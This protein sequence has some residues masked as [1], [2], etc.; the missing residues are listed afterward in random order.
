MEL[1]S[2]LQHLNEAPENIAFADTL[3]VIEALYDFTPT[4]FRNGDLLNEAGKNSGSCKIFSFAR[5]HQLTPAQ[6]LHCFGDY[7]RKDVLEQPDAT[8]HQNIRNFMKTGWAGIAFSG[9]ALI[10][11]T[12]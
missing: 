1:Q 2:F 3:A 12:I 4:E 9:E 10:R 8:D 5:L 11:K 7:Y 6:T